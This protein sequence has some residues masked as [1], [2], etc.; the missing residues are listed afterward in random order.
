MSYAILQAALRLAEVGIPVFPTSGKMPVTMHGFKDATTHRKTI[1]DWFEHTDYNVA[2]V[3]ASAGWLVV[4][5]DLGADP[6]LVSQLPP[7]FTVRTPSGG[8]HYYY[9]DEGLGEIGNAKL[10]ARVDIRHASGYVL[11]PPSAGYVQIDRR[12]PVPLPKWVSEKLAHRSEAPTHV[13]GSPVAA[14]ELIATLSRIDPGCDYNAWV[15]VLAAIAATPCCADKAAIALTWSN[16][17]FGFSA[18]DV[19]ANAC[20]WDYDME[21]KLASFGSE[22]VG[23]GTL[24]YLAY[25]PATTAI[26][27]DL[28]ADR[29]TAEAWLARDDLAEREQLIGPISKTSRVMLVAPTGVGKTHVAMAIGCSIASGKAWLPHWNVPSP[30]RVLYI[31]GEMP[32]TLIRDR[33]KEAVGRVGVENLQ[34]RLTFLNYAD[35][36]SELGGFPAM[37]S[38]DGQVFIDDW[39][40]QT[41]AKFVIFDNIQSLTIGDMKETDSWR[42]V[43]AFCR[44]LTDQ[45]IGQLW[46]HHANKDGSMYGDKTRAYQFDTVMSLKPVDDS[47]KET[48]ELTFDL[49]YQKTRELHPE[50]TAA[51]YATGRVSL[52]K[53]LGW[54]FRSK[55]V[56]EER[57]IVE[58][59]QGGET[60]TTG[61]LV[62]LL[63]INKMTLGRYA[64]GKW[65]KYVVPGSKPLRWTM[66]RVTDDF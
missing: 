64:K 7:T 2:I 5:V 58:A 9:D 6:D 1:T 14:D 38:V 65:A 20:G 59:V 51:W 25:P 18:A 8:H 33:I 34:G 50:K 24:L 12:D 32:A 21:T 19:P 40:K 45:G 55:A 17:G 3:P 11:V 35:F 27:D 22:G 49:G 53:S 13:E 47:D 15:R 61:E 36:L 57:A 48:D 44:K 56:I 66:P 43:Q 60:F 39:L 16:G 46:V 42:M 4:D 30:E 62:D 28:N 52:S 63:G 10:A 26:P 23:Y 31:D 41:G 54:Q 37:E 29:F